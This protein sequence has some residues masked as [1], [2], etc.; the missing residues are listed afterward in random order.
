MLASRGVRLLPFVGTVSGSE[1]V[2]T[3][4]TAVRKRR[5]T[6]ARCWLDNVDARHR[7][8]I[9]VPLTSSSQ[10]EGSKSD[11]ETMETTEDTFRKLMI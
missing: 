5:F 3:V 7:Y 11:T 9:C 2:V 6:W 8:R 4:L 1:R 10:T